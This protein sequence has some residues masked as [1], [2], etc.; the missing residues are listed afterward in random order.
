MGQKMMEL[1]PLD[2]NELYDLKK[3]EAAEVSV[4]VTVD[5]HEAYVQQ[6]R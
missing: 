4:S 1:E 6:R 5:E 3:R 2:R